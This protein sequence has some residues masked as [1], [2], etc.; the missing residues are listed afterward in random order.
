ME[1]KKGGGER[2]AG[3]RGEGGAEGEISPLPALRTQVVIL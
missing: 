3:G 2:G 1:K